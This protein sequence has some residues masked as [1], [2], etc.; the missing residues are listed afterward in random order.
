MNNLVKIII[1]ASLSIVIGVLLLFNSCVIIPPTNNGI[2]ITLGKI[3][4]KIKTPGLHA[5]IPFFQD[6]IN[7]SLQP[8]QLDIDIPVNSNGAITKDNQTIGIDCVLFYS[9]N[10][11]LLIKLYTEY[12]IEK[13]KEIIIKELTETI[14]TEIG[15]YDIFMVPGSQEKIATDIKNK[16]LQRLEKYPIIIKEFK[17]VNYDWCDEFDKQIQETMQRAQ[18]V[19]QKEQ[20]LLIAEQEAQKQVKLAE[21]EKRA[22]ITKSEG[23][24][25]SAK[26]LADAKALEGE[27]IK[28]YNQSIQI[29]LNVELQL[30][31]LEIEKIK[32][33]K[34]NGQYV[35]VN[36]Y[37]PIP[38]E[39]GKLIP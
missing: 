37:S 22:L 1:I 5:K 27:G 32:A 10:K 18:Q 39:H 4:E 19:K 30:R 2:L 36:N 13:I 9:Y 6:I 7:L 17:V 38:F 33:E 29:N 8:M 34:W 31:Q 12:G 23:Q 26:L 24:K 20:E 21:A 15:Q 14:K 28:K 35:P 16:I 25:E 11:E 3:D